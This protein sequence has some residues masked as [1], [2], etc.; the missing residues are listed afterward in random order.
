[1]TPK[2]FEE[3]IEKHLTIYLGPLI[4]VGG[5]VE[6]LNKILSYIEKRIKK[7]IPK[8]PDNSDLPIIHCPDCGGEMYSDSYVVHTISYCEHCGQAIDWSDSDE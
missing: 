1:M 3:I 5:T 8:K 7:Q 4:E 2:R 6:E